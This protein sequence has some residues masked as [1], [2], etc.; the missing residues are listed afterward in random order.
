VLGSLLHTLQDFLLA[1]ELN[2]VRRYV[3]LELH[4]RAGN[5]LSIL[6]LA[7]E[8][9]GD[10]TQLFGPVSLPSQP[11]V[12]YAR[13][14]DTAGKAFQRVLVKSIAPQTLRVLAP[15]PADLPTGGVMTYTFKV[16]NSGPSGTFRVTA[17]DDRGFVT[18]ALPAQLDLTKNRKTKVSVQLTIPSGALPGTS[19]TL[20]VSVESLTAPGVRNFAVVDSLVASPPA[21]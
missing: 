9:G 14:T 2:R 15:I 13:G 20:T 10:P 16:K 18:S 11:F 3:Q 1:F 5:L 7:P 19:D 17:S 8:T 4:D 21:P 6:S 12:V